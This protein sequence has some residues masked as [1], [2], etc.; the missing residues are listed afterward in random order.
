VRHI[1]PVMI[2]LWTSGQFV[3][4]YVCLFCL[5]FNCALILDSIDLGTSI[6]VCMYVFGTGRVRTS[7][8]SG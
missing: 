3:R 7:R 5:L 4:V 2:K 1:D 6:V 8:S